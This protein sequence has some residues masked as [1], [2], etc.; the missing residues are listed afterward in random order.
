MDGEGTQMLPLRQCNCEEEVCRGDQGETPVSS[1]D[2]S[3][4]R[5]KS[6]ACCSEFGLGYLYI[7]SGEYVEVIKYL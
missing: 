1:A 6:A 7:Q 2:N 3:V 4:T 5:V